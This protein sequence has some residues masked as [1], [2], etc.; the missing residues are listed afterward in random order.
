MRLVKT[1]QSQQFTLHIAGE[2]LATNRGRKPMRTDN[3]PLIDLSGAFFRRPFLS[4]GLMAA[5]FLTPVAM[6][7]AEAANIADVRA[8]TQSTTAIV[9]IDPGASAV[10]LQRD[11]RGSEMRTR[12]DRGQRG[13]RGQRAERSGRSDWGNRRFNT[14]TRNARPA[15]PRVERQTDRRPDV[16]EARR[17]VRQNQRQIERRNDVREARRDIRQDE[18]RDVRQD[19]RRD[20]RQDYRRDYRQEARRDY[21]QDRRADARR[22]YRQ[23]RRAWNRT[24]RNDRRYNWRDYRR[25]NRS[26]YSLGR[27]YA[28]I[29]GYNY[30][31]LN[32]G[33]YLGSGFYGNNYW[34]NDPWSYRLPPAYGNYRWVRYYDDVLLVDVY[35][36]YVADVIYDFFY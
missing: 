23:D 26:Y 11:G 6:A 20:T 29:R 8:S 19:A 9:K 14:E 36:G 27:Y 18:R 10:A 3:K 35:T 31:R 15:E 13:E 12:T 16:R 28:P 34:I 7:Q 2:P 4:L 33:L 32:I 30:R 21:R 25:A 24:W 1:S 5:T 17:D 22:D